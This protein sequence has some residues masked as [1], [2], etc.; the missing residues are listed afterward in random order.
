MV[1]EKQ[2]IFYGAAI[3]GAQDRSERSYVNEKIIQ[4]IKTLGYEVLS[5]H[6]T[7][8]DFDDTADKLEESIGPLPPVGK[9][10]TVFIRK[11][12]IQLI[13][14]DII[15][16]VFEVST[17]SLGTGIEIAHAYLRD[18]MGLSAI[19]VIALYQKGFWPNKLSAMINGISEKD[20]PH[21]KLIKY[22]LPID[23]KTPL[24]KAINALNSHKVAQN[25]TSPV[26]TSGEVVAQTCSCCGHHE[27]G[28]NI[29]GNKYI[30]LKPGMKV[31][32]IRNGEKE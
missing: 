27:I 5:E 2:K 9:E 22:E 24:S 21:F 6:T 19:P 23:I 13:E 15:A 16:A 20:I 31:K 8:L 14:S 11:K 4:T 12:M 18:R 7:G 1:G 17:P 30:P 32:I 26:S 25:K 10:R 3:Q 29:Y 28:V